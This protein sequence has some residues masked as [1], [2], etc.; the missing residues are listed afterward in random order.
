[1]GTGCAGSEGVARAAWNF[2][3][4]PDPGGGSVLSTETR[5]RADD[6]AARRRF[7]LYWLAIRP[8]SGLIRRLMLRAIRAEAEQASA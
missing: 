4:V 3:V 1:M 8:G 2:A 7:R 5:V 6:P